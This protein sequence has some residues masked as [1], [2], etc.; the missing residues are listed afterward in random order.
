MWDKP[1]STILI[2]FLLTVQSANR[3]NSSLMDIEP[4]MLT[5]STRGLV[6]YMTKLFCS[7]RFTYRFNHIYVERSLSTGLADKLVNQINSCMAAG[8]LVSRYSFDS[9]LEKKKKLDSQK[10]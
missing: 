3:A 1:R 10:I 7:N 5:E 4:I 6:E 9:H 8:V 2:L